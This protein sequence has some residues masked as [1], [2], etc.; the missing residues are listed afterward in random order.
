MAKIEERRAELLAAIPPRY[1]GW[2]HFAA[3][4]GTVLAAVTACALAVDAPTWPEL[5]MLPA[6]LVFANAFEWW[7]HKGPLHRPVR[8]LVR[9]YRRHACA[10]HVMFTDRR[11]AVASGRELALV[12]FPPWVLPQLVLLVS[13]L[14]GALYLVRPNLAWLFLASALGYYLLYEWLHLC[15]HL[16]PESWIGRRRLVRALRRHHLRHHEPARM[17]QGNFNVSFPLTDWLVGSLLP[18]A[19]GPARQDAAEPQS[20]AAPLD[21]SGA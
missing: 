8:P 12:L 7:V 21:A 4:N 14:V 17:T 15:H 1:P 2:A 3:I 11:M 20:A 5:A 13:P 16:P 19:P 18:E 6:A 10:H 9:L